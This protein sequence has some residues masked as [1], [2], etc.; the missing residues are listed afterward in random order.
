M[1]LS[2]LCR[3]RRQQVKGVQAVVSASPKQAGAGATLV[4]LNM[5]QQS[6]RSEQRWAVELQGAEGIPAFHPLPLQ[7]PQYTSSDQRGP[8]SLFLREQNLSSV[9]RDEGS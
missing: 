5:R 9:D 2:G 8:P 7:L 3:P 6:E 4:C 1:W